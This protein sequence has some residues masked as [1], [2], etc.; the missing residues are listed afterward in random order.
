[1]KT[2]TSGQVL[3]PKVK[4]SAWST[5]LISLA[6]VVLAGVTTWATGLGPDDVPMLGVWAL[7]AIT[8]LTGILNTL[9]GYL[10]RDPL[11]DIGAEAVDAKVAE[12]AP[13]PAPT[14]TPTVSGPPWENPGPK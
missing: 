3:S 9:A 10:K 2:A 7:P 5:L 1:M 4:A 13:E 6:G 11:R 12:V 8:L 14:V